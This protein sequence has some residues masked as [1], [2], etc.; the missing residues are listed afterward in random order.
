MKKKKKDDQQ[1]N[2]PLL[3][4][5]AIRHWGLVAGTIGL[6]LAGGAAYLTLKFWE[7]EYEAKQFV[8]VV[9]NRE[10]TD[11]IEKGN[12]KTDPKN[13]LAAVRSPLLLED[14][15]VM[16]EVIQR[17]D[18]NVESLQSKVRV[19]NSGGD[20]FSIVMRDKDPKFAALVAQSLTEK[21]VE[22]HH[23][24][25]DANLGSLGEGLQEKIETAE[26]EIRSVAAHL[27][28]LQSSLDLGS[29]VDSIGATDV[30][31][32][33]A[34]GSLL[35]D[36]LKKKFNENVKLENLNRQLGLLKASKG[37]LEETFTES[38]ITNATLSNGK[39]TELDARIRE[40][41]QSRLEMDRLGSSHPKVI[42]LDKTI[43][44]LEAQRE[45]QQALVKESAKESWLSWKEGEINDQIE[46]IGKQIASSVNVI[47]TYTSEIT[48]LAESRDKSNQLLFEF[49]QAL[50]KQDRAYARLDLWRSQQDRIQSKE[51]SLY[52]VDIAIERA[53]KVP[54][55]PVEKYPLKLLAMAILGGFCLPFALAIAYEL[56]LRR[57]GNSEQVRQQIPVT[58]LGEVANLPV[59][60]GSSPRALTSKRMTKQLR[61]YEESVDNLNAVLSHIDE[62]IRR[63]FSVSSALSN[64]GK[65]TLAMQLAI[66]AARSQDSRTL[67]IDADLRSPSMHRLFDA[68]L[69]QGLCDVLAGSASLDDVV[70]E[71]P[72][73]NLDLI[74]AGRIRSNPNRYF[75]GNAWIELLEEA[76]GK[77]D[78]IVVD[79]PP[80]LAAS[81]SLAI[82]KECDYTLLCMLRDVSRI[83]SVNRA[84][85]RLVAAKVQVVGS[86]FSGVPHHEY[87]S[88][89]GCYE[90]NM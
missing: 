80:I 69:E 10:F 1:N 58:L 2:I 8:R 83:D 76:K 84:H 73:E 56:R 85:E 33:D 29:D 62:C 87:A 22:Y 19:E 25:R 60:T 86:A 28:T 89:Y 18:L 71:T 32:A 4:F 51:M 64:E 82:S 13:E 75:S 23:R 67:L 55:E 57:L 53:V 3:I 34:D 66:S 11:I 14:I 12:A 78:Q 35:A 44:R 61:L 43:A 5:S 47:E 24:N 68:P 65:T 37:N 46:D 38:L 90:Y 81:E 59:R 26:E 74:T 42:S 21:F 6:L 16:D 77:Y 17:D 41:R 45:E 30:E 54:T 31:S 40:L 70:E 7:P 49:N 63:V 52:L 79:T 15:L 39:L 48:R 36:L 72:I 20:L 50:K 9:Q 88:K 27:Q